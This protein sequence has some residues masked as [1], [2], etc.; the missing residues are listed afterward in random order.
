MTSTEKSTAEHMACDSS[1]NSRVPISG[2]EVD[3]GLIRAAVGGSVSPYVAVLS[4]GS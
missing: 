2:P 4:R 1:R 3:T